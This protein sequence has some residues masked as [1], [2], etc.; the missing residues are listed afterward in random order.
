[1]I[2]LIGQEIREQIMNLNV[3]NLTKKYKNGKLALDDISF[4]VNDGEVFGLLGPNGAGK[5]TTMKIM[6]TILK[7]TKGKILVG[8]DEL[9]SNSRRI[10]NKF[11]YI[12]Q[13]NSLD[14]QLTGRENLLLQAMLYHLKDYNDRMYEILELIELGEDIDTPVSR[15]SG[16]MKKRL[17]I[18]CALM[19]S[20]EL[21]FLDE[22]TLGLDVEVRRDIWE[23]LRRLNESYNVTLVVT[24]HYL[25]EADSICNRIAI[26][27]EGK[28][29]AIGNPD[30]L[31]KKIGKEKIE[32][33]FESLKDVE[34]VDSVVDNISFILDRKIIDNTMV[35]IVD[36]AD[37]RMFEIY[38][39]LR[40][41]G[42]RITGMNNKKISLDD[43][44][45]H[46]TGYR[47]EKN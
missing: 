41:N 33:T 21:L 32:I 19:S 10:K 34:K 8:E 15:Y 20:P 1:M 26:I 35:L 23:Y 25:E 45:L 18:G 22:P 3:E 46:Y 39:M 2:L 5:S 42:I 43:V 14:E 29:V 30:E 11:G 24:T 13:D 44:Y 28:I 17:E 36:D 38:D 47:Y 12:A 27:N 6:T 7:P 37:N 31:K 4:S 40:E 9:Q 16:G